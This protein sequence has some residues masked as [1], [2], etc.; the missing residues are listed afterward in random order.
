MKRYK[1]TLTSASD[2]TVTGYSPRLSGKL[3]S[4]EYAKRGS[5]GYDDGVGVTITDEAT[6]KQLW[7]ESNVNASKVCMPR[8]ATHTNAGV[9]AT[10]DGTVAALDKFALANTRVKF[11]LAQAGN[12][13]AGDF[14]VHA[15]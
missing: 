12:A 11:V 4:I 9:P 6:G 10:L 8:G 15:E 5:G 14:Y 3:H 2:G 13:K 1:V 7:T